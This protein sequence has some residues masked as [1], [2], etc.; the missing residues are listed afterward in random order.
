MKRLLLILFLVLAAVPCRAQI[1]VAV[2][3]GKSPEEIITMLGKPLP[4]DGDEDALYIELRYPQ[5]VF[6]L[7]TIYFKETNKKGF[8]LES[9]EIDSPAFCVLSDV[10]PG[11]IKVG[12]KAADLESFDFAGCKYGDYREVNNFKRA[13]EP[14]RIYCPEKQY[15]ADYVLFDERYTK[16]VFCVEDGIIKAIGMRTAQ[17]WYPEV[18]AKELSG[19]GLDVIKKK[20]WM[21][22]SS[23]SDYVPREVK[24]HPDLLLIDTYASLFLDKTTLIIVG[25]YSSLPAIYVLSDVIPG[26]IKVGDPL[27]RLQLFDFVHTPY[28][29]GNPNNGLKI[30]GENHFGLFLDEWGFYYFTVKNGMISAIDFRNSSRYLEPSDDLPF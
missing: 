18:D 11:G 29:K 20:L 22:C 12:D 14:T 17:D 10:Y 15:R 25:L 30:L 23:G 16:Y 13:E 4:N 19:V 28:G 7:D 8:S 24:D 6:Y 9:F 27:E 21:D 1:D 26:G 2:L 5:G 3:N